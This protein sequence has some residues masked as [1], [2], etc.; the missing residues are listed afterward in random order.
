LV[1]LLITPTGVHFYFYFG[2]GNGMPALMDMLIPYSQIG[3]DVVRSASTHS[4]H[5]ALALLRHLFQV[6]GYQRTANP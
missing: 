3:P 4:W 2:S 5:W 1:G 6:G